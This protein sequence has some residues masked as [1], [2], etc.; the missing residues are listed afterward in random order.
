[1]PS[2][3][4]RDHSESL[5]GAPPALQAEPEQVHPQESGDQVMVS[6]TQD[7]P[8]RLIANHDSFLETIFSL[9]SMSRQ[10]LLTELAPISA[11]HIQAGLLS[12]TAKVSSTWS[13]SMYVH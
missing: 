12:I 3:K 13:M 1:M 9:D 11:P 10:F 6:I 8:D 7:V 5:P 2:K 4:V